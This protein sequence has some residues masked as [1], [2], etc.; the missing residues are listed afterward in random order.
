MEIPS[1][2]LALGS[3]SR[4]GK[5]VVEDLCGYWNWMTSTP[6]AAVVTEPQPE[7]AAGVEELAAQLW[8]PRRRGQGVAGWQLTPSSPPPRATAHR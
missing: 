3:R 1:S 6:S 8:H 4:K 7:A 2:P 5:R